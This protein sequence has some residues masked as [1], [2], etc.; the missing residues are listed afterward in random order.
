MSVYIKGM[1]MPKSCYE[2][3]FKHAFFRNLDCSK[4]QGMTGFDQLP[5]TESRNP[6]CPL[7]PVPDHGRLG[8][9]DAI[10]KKIA[11]NIDAAKKSDEYDW[12]NACLVAEDFVM[13]APTIIPAEEV[14]A[15][16]Y[17]TAGN[18]HWTG[19]HSGEHIV[20]ADKEA[21]G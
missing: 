21:D 16:G 7:V 14:Y 9:L 20:P 2:C 13:G 10:I 3:I 17:D 18:Y 12:W 6:D 5:Y 11:E 19:T 1:E 4:L 15:Q 8:D